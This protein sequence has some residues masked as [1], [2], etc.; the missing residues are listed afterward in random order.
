MQF[1]TLSSNFEYLSVSDRNISDGLIFLWASRSASMAACCAFLR[2]FSA[3]FAASATFFAS[4]SRNK[5]SRFTSLTADVQSEIKQLYKDHS[6]CL[7]YKT[8]FDKAGPGLLTSLTSVPQ[9][10]LPK[11]WIRPN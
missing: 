7:C 9:Y 5:V 11:H 1:H 6:F 2:S 3:A 8:F 4:F 10:R